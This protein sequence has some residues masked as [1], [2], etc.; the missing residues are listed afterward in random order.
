LVAPLTARD[1]RIG[2]AANVKRARSIAVFAMALAGALPAQVAISSQESDANGDAA[3]AQ[4][5]LPQVLARLGSD[6]PAN[7][8]WGA[9]LAQHHGLRGAEQELNKALV[10]FAGVSGDAAANVRLA[11]LDAL[12]QLALTAPMATVAQCAKGS[13]ADAALVL[14]ARDP[15]ANASCLLEVFRRDASHSKEG[16]DWVSQRGIAAGNLLAQ[17]RDPAFV[18]ALLQRATD[19]L[20]I[21]VVGAGQKRDVVPHSVG[22]GM[23]TACRREPRLPGFP[24]VAEYLVSSH[25]STGETILGNGRSTVTWSRTE[26]SGQFPVGTKLEWLRPFVWEWLEAQ[27]PGFAALRARATVLEFTSADALT[28]QVTAMRKRLEGAFAAKVVTLVAPEG[29]TAQPAQS[30]RL[31]LET[32]LYDGRVDDNAARPS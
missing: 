27:H 19:T 29:L 14:L 7:V 28:E 5:L 3:V 23:V 30:L 18:V 16:T 15:T 13:S 24:P 31:Q 6:E 21:T 26:H 12:L 8:A 1:A 10:R 22:E 11:L 32:V 4:R 17:R 20:Q 25:S 2:S 9:Y